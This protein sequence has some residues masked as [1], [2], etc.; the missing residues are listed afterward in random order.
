[1]LRKYIKKLIW[2]AFWCVVFTITERFD[3]WVNFITLF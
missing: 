1:M 2:F 3:I